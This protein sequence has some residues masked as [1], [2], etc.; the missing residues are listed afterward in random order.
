MRIS[1]WSS[2]VCSSDLAMRCSPYT[3]WYQNSI[4]IEGSPAAQHHAEVHGN[5][6]YD[7]FVAQFL[8]AHA[9]WQ[10]EPWADLFAQ[11]GARYVV[12]VTKHHDGV[13]LWP[14]DTPNPHKERW[15]SARDLV[16]DLAGAVRARG[17]RC[18]TY[19]SEISEERRVGY[20]GVSSG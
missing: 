6:P 20:E 9:G 19:Y 4:S 17:M 13:L 16:G 8:S 2:D 11:A 18:G 15:A 3:E 7:D 12:L 14:S 5:R 10:P 1:D